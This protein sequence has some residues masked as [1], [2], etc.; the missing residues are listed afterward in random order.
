MLHHILQCIVGDFDRRF[1][2]CDLV[3]I[4]LH[5]HLRH[6]REQISDRMSRIQRC[7]FLRLYRIVIRQILLLMAITVKIQA[8]DILAGH[9]H[10]EHPVKAFQETHIFDLTDL[11]CLIDR[12][13]PAIPA[14]LRRVS[15]FY[16]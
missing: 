1:E 13:L 8:F 3:C 7:V 4:L 9:H 16:K 5:P 6:I 15:L 14:L 12:H 11:F 2:L 10:I